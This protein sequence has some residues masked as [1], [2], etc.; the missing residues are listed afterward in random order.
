MAWAIAVPAALSV[1]GT[2]TGAAGKIKGGQATSSADLYKAQVA[3]NNAAA[4]DMAGTRAVEGG[5]VASDVEGLRTRANVGA[6]KAKQAASNIDVN[7]GSAVD[8]RKGIAQ[9]GRLNQLTTL[10][11]AQLQGWGYRVQAARE[12]AQAGLDT[13]EAAGAT[14]GAAIGAVGGLLN[15]ASSLPFNWL[16]GGGSSEDASATQTYGSSRPA[17]PS[18]ALSGG[19]IPGGV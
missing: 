9:A 4:L 16:T 17:Y 10:S 13:K 18:D 5:E 19:V 2:A 6:A 11:N 3:R 14:Q 1:L 12:E 7:V 15:S 8:V